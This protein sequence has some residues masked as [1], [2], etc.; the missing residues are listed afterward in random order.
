MLLDEGFESVSIAL[1]IG[2]DFKPE[3]SLTVNHSK[4]PVTIDHS[5]LVVLPTADLALVYLDNM[6]FSSNFTLVILAIKCVYT[7]LCSR[8]TSLLLFLMRSALLPRRSLEL[9]DRSS[10]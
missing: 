10:P 9:P 6:A 1:V 8:S 4:D 2:A 5:A 7:N 3:A